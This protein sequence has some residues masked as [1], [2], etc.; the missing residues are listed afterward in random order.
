MKPIPFSGMMCY[1]T[2]IQKEGDFKIRG[3][4]NVPN[5]THPQIVRY[6]H[7][8]SPIERDTRYNMLT[9]LLKEKP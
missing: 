2:D 9:K 6:E 7:F 4:I 1:P 5:N 8:A 3:T